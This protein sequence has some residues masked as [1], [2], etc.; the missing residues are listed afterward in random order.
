MLNSQ[1][2]KSRQQDTGFGM[3]TQEEGA[4]HHKEASKSKSGSN[5]LR[6]PVVRAQYSSMDGE[7]ANESGQSLT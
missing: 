6:E 4:L 2:S 3:E 5:R 7:R 1:T